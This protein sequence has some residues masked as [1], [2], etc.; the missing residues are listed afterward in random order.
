[1]G[2]S[3]HRKPAQPEAEIVEA[4]PPPPEGRRWTPRTEA[5]P[6]PGCAPRAERRCVQGDAWWF[7]SCEN[8]YEKADE[9]ER[10]GCEDG[11]CRPEEDCG[12]IPV[13]GR[14]EGEIAETC[15]GGR[16]FR[17]DCGE[18]GERCVMTE[19]GPAC[20]PI[21]DE[22]CDWPRG[23]TRCEGDV[24]TACIEGRLS[25][26]DCRIHGGTCEER[27]AGVHRCVVR[28]A[29]RGLPECG[30]CGCEP[31]SS[32][33]VCDGRDND[34]DGWVDE[35][36]GCEPV[37]VV[38]FVVEDA[39]GESSWSDADIE[40]QIDVVNAAFAREDDLGIELRLAEIVALPRAEWV[41]LDGTEV[42]DVVQSGA[43]YPAR[44]AFFVPIVFTDEIIVEEV[45]RP[46]LATVPNGIC[47]GIRRTHEPQSPVGLVALAKRHWP[48]TLAHEVGH[49]FGLC[50]THA[51]Q[52]DAVEHVDPEAEEGACGRPCDLDADGLCDTAPDPGPTVCRV[53]EACAITCDDASM[54]DP[55]NVMAYYP[56]CRNLFTPEQARL[57]RTSLWLRRQWHP[58][59]WGE[60]CACDPRRHGCPE[61][62]TCRNHAA[63]DGGTQWLCGLEGSSVPGGLCQGGLDCSKD[64]VCVIM[65]ESGEGRCIRPCDD[66]T[67]DCDCREV[68]TFPLPLCLD[69]AFPRTDA[70]DG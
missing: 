39:R 18:T 40:E 50:H 17:I 33:E 11:T 43:I 70:V 53:D 35:D 52:A 16:P 49:F 62:M 51:D 59:V 48:T 42:N 66:T 13:P 57:V 37:D 4:P 55:T 25:S 45:P 69:D 21:T 46:G 30:A 58:C 15:A 65:G 19:D 2:W 22:D 60:G 26:T 10:W 36:G 38:A 61:G 6:A 7:D 1:M 8:P 47:G 12:A 56:T 32:D 23:T 41:E 9:C 68:E 64:S 44:D 5:R 67:P 27:G 20:R 29:A 34:Q 31:E 28:G 24:L 54:P 3:F 63:D 14:C